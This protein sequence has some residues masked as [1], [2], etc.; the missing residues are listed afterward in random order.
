MTGLASELIDDSQAHRLPRA[1]RTL[2]YHIIL[3]CCAC[4]WTRCGRDDTDNHCIERQCKV[5]LNGCKMSDEECCRNRPLPDLLGLGDIPTTTDDETCGDGTCG[6][7]P[8]CLDDCWAI[9]VDAPN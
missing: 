3:Q 7:C 2:P 5:C 8:E 4:S 1:A 6:S 9:P